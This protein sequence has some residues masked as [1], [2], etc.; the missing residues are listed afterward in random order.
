MQ[1]FRQLGAS[2][3]RVIV[4][5]ALIAPSPTK[6]KRP[7]FNATDPNGYPAAGWRP[8]DAIVRAAHQD[9]LTAYFDVSGGAPRW[10]EASN[11]LG[12]PGEPV[13]YLAWQ[14]NAAAYGQF[15]KAIATRYD[16]H[17]TPKGQSAPLPAVHFWSLFNEPNFGEDLGPQASNDSTVASAPIMYRAL[18][19]AGWNALRATGHGRDTI[20]IGEFAAEGF[21]PGPFPKKTG[22][23]PGWYGQTRP[24]LFVRELY[25][26]DTCF[27]QLRG[28]AAR[29]TGCPTNTA[30]SRKFRSQNPGLFGASG[31]ADHPYPQGESPTSLSGNKVDFARFQD[32][33]TFQRT[34]DRA[35][36]AYGTPK[37]LPIYNTEYGYITSPPKG[38]P[39][40][41]PATAAYY[42]N[43]AE[44]L[45]WKQPW[46]KS[47]MQYLLADPPPNVGVYSGFA[48]GLEFSNGK[49]KPSYDA[50]RLPLYLPHTSFSRNANEEIW[51]AARPAPFMK[52][53]GAGTPTVAIQL[54]GQTIKTLNVTGSGGYFDINMRFPK[55]GTVRLAYTYPTTNPFLP[56]ADL[57]ETVFS[58]SVRISVH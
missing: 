12:N 26:V 22:G 50:F 52:K 33:A 7:S 16:G 42:I 31:V 14:P 55:S 9:G 27:L 58:R 54:N 2:T 18:V 38:K 28:S 56:P 57:G 40:V 51:G 30:G 1:E 3:V 53:D 17:F 47:Y 19:N 36:G 4:P 34:L 45:S 46:V 29:A 37:K 32:L 35:T 24:L 21:E 8:F 13:A 41:S 39:Y 25:C 49:H 44:Y 48:S 5:W 10:A 11:P 43:W 6:T 20:L 15:V 23:L